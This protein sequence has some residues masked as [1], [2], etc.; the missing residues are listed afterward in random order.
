MSES[1]KWT[2]LKQLIEAR[3]AS[4]ASGRVQIHTTRY[5]RAHD[6]EGELFVTLDGNKI[7]GSAYYQ[8]LKALVTM[9]EDLGRAPSPAE[10]QE[11]EQRLRERGIAD[12]GELHRAMFESLNQPIE[13]M[14]RDSRPLIRALGILDARCGKRRLSKLDHANEHELVRCVYRLRRPSRQACLT[15]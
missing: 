15:P 14:L 4:E 7:Y 3:F 8:Y 13:D 1:M 2:K 11:F 12:H 5:R 10:G 6:D 9:R